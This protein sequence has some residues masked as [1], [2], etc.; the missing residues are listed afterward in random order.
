[1]NAKNGGGVV[2]PPDPFDLE[3]LRLPANYGDDLGV[4]KL[5][6]TL[7]VRRPDRQWFVRTHAE[8]HLETL[9]V[10]LKD[11]RESYLVA[12][13]IRA[14][15][16]EEAAAKVLRLAITR[17]QVLFFWPIRLPDSDG[18]HD[19]W[20]ASALTAAKEAE[21]RWVSVKANQHAGAYEIHVATASI[22]EPHWDEVLDGKSLQDLLRI[23][24]R[25]RVIDTIDHPVIKQLRGTA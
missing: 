18:R 9:V 3:A 15:I 10:E 6:A 13:A 4:K 17:Q 16:A 24:F 21:T 12:P 8:L 11:A 2:Q 14:E 1:M 7:P 20:N 25:D 22:P 5:L 23:A 19:N